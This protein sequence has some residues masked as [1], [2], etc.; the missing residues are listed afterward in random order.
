MVAYC[1]AAMAPQIDSDSIIIER[2][3]K[4][5]AKDEREIARLFLQSYRGMVHS[6]VMQPGF[7]NHQDVQDILHDAVSDLIS[8]VR[9][10]KFE[11]KEARLSTFFYAIAKN[12][13]LNVIRQRAKEITFTEIPEE[14]RPG[15]A[16]GELVD[17]L[18]TSEERSQVRDALSKIDDSCFK[19]LHKY[20]ILDMKLK[21]IATE[22]NMSEELVKKRHERC[23]KK[24]KIYLKK[25]PRVS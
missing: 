11:V 8:Y 19:I 9:S 18:I 10:D 7:G 5:T 2:L 24:L 12:K 15:S 21:D 14:I 17:D 3:K 22:L 20:W 1:Y 13:W 25:D 16:H 23:R 6:I 4:G